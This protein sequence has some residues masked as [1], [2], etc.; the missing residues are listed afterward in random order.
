[1]FPCFF[2]FSDTLLGLNVYISISRSASSS[3]ACSCP[4]I[5]S[6]SY[7]FEGLLNEGESRSLR[8][9][10]RNWKQRLGTCALQGLGMSSSECL[11][12][13]SFSLARSQE[14]DAGLLDTNEI[15]YMVVRYGVVWC[16]AFLA[17]NCVSL[18]LKGIPYISLY[19]Q[20]DANDFYN[21]YYPPFTTYSTFTCHKHRHHH[22]PTQLH[23]P[24][25]ISL[26]YLLQ[27]SYNFIIT[28]P[29]P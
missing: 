22:R 2:A 17:H 12:L 8:H 1:M 10:V 21:S 18:V 28:L 29:Q 11:H 24:G 14:S 9:C 7:E 6:A 16:D 19:K 20:H 27:K 5:A 15:R 13:T 4:I 23:Q 26:S 3:V 25:A